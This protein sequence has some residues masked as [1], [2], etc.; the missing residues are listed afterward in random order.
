MKRA[1]EEWQAYR[2]PTGQ[3][4]QTGGTRSVRDAFT[5]PTAYRLSKA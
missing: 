1:I 2:I 4:E 5:Y 3:T